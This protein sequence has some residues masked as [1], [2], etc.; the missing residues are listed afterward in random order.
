DK[1][2]TATIGT[3]SD[4]VNHPAHYTAGGIETIDFIRAKLT[5]D[6]FLGYCKGNVLKYVSR[7]SLKGRD[8][9][10]R[11]AAKYLEFVGTGV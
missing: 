3:D 8:E 5:P 11:K 7:A 6:E 1:A 10:L 4:P 9:D 2:I